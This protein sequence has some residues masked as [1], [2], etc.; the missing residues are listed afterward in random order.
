MQH[1][2]LIV[3]FGASASHRITVRVHRDAPL[4]IKHLNLYR[5][6]GLNPTGRLLQKVNEMEIAECQFTAVAWLVCTEKSWTWG[7]CSPLLPVRI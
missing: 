7:E 1:M 6:T 2:Q 5:I 4:Y 3:M